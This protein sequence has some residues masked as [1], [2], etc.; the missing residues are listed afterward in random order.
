MNE[1]LCKA[2]VY[3]LVVQKQIT[4]WA[5]LRNRAAHGDRGEYTAPDVDDMI[6]SVSRFIAEYL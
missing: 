3:N 2:G 5:E 1:N 6:K 4:A